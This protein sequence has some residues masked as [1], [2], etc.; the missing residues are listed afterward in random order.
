MFGKYPKTVAAIVA[1]NTKNTP[2]QLEDIIDIIGII[3]TG[4]T[5]YFTK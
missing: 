3:S 5:T 1:I 2:I 4:N